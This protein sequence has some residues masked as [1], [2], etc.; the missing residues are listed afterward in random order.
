MNRTTDW[1]FDISIRSNGDQFQATQDIDPHLHYAKLMREQC[2]NSEDTG[3]RHFATIP[4]TVALEILTKYGIDMN[5]QNVDPDD[6]KK[7][8]YI[9]NTE[10]P[11]L[12]T[13]TVFRGDK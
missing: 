4:D 1:N 6:M 3:F 11:L 7:L 9:I 8:K 2:G 5:A 12:R 10:Y 13:S